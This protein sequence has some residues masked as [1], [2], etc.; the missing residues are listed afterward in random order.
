M[1]SPS[2]PHHLGNYPYTSDLLHL[3]AMRPAQ[4]VTDPRLLGIHSPLQVDEWSELLKAHPDQQYVAFLLRGMTFGFRVGFNRAQKLRPA[5]RNMKSALERPSVIQDYLEQESSQ[6]TNLGPFCPQDMKHLSIHTSKFG[7][8][9]KKHAPGKWRLIVDL[10]SPDNHSV[11]DGIDPALTSL[12]YTRIEQVV[13]TVLDLGPG[14]QLAKIDVKS[15]FRVMPIHPDDRPLLG[16]LWEDQLYVDAALPFGLRSAP[17]LFNALTDAL[18]W[19]AKRLGIEF[20]W[21]YLDDFITTGR[22]DSEECAFF[23]HLLINLCA[24][25]GLPLA[26]EKVEGPSTCLPFLGIEIDSI[27][28]ELRLPAEKLSG[29]QSLLN[30]WEK[31]T[32][33][34]QKELQSLAGH[35]QHAASIVRPGRSFIRRLYDLQ[36]RVPKPH[37]HVHLSVGIRSDL[38]WW[39]TYIEQ[40]NG[41]TF[42]SACAPVPPSI[43]FETDASGSWG[44]GAVWQPHWFQLAWESEREQQQNIATL[45]LVP[46]VISAAVWGKHWQGQSVLCR[47]DN[48]AVVHS[49][50]SRSCRD[51]NLMHLLRTLFFFEAHFH[52][53]LHAEHVAGVDNTLADHLSRNN[54][55]SFMQRC[56]RIPDSTPTSILRSLRDMLLHSKPDWNSPAWTQLFKA[57]LK[58]V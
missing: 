9:P 41:V 45:E 53:S 43:S 18:E 14:A 33:C 5:K 50:R 31:K 21:H 52:F 24:R 35:L 48:L 15:A 20:L 37:H 38:S 1:A 46:I 32:R 25:L 12:S 47:C 58:Q 30:E 27:A 23:L 54:V 34:T 26:R 11:N 10:S 56:S 49:L 22:P 40:W 44:A 57:T 4:A 39:R 8:I 17:K 7:V 55:S 6:Q 3:E 51:P 42:L 13:Q 19:I 16:M 29:I 2:S 28:Q 36:A